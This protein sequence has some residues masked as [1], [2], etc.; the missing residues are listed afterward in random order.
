MNYQIAIKLWNE[1][2]KEITLLYFQKYV[3]GL[4]V[5]TYN[6]WG[7]FCNI[8]TNNVITVDNG[9]DLTIDPK[10]Y[11]TYLNWRKNKGFADTHIVIILGT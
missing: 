4:P 1:G 2:N 7:S 10:I 8:V 5:S 3:I 6:F 9:E 11:F